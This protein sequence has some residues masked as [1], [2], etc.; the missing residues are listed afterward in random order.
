MSGWGSG[1]P[2][3]MRENTQR[4]AASENAPTQQSDQDGSDETDGSTQ[5]TPS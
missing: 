4:K 2:G 1:F 5:Q 3:V